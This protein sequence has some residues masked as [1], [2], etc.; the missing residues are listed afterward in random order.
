[1]MLQHAR[2]AKDFGNGVGVKIGQFKSHFMDD[3][4]RH[5]AARCGSGSNRLL[6]SPIDECG[7]RCSLGRACWAVCSCAIGGRTERATHG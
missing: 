7:L 1:M 6:D 3:S 2:R 5:D 4:I